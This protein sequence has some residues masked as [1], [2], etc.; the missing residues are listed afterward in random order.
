MGVRLFE[1]QGSQAMNGQAL[2]R[3]VEITRLHWGFDKGGSG[4]TQRPRPV[5]VER[6]VASETQFAARV[7]G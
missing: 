1:F 6:R 7:S 4:R 5:P 3:I 2:Q